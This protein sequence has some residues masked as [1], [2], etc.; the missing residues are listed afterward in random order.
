MFKLSCRRGCNIG[1]D[2]FAD[3]ESPTGVTARTTVS[4]ST[5]EAEYWAASE[6]DIQV[7]YTRNLLQVENMG[8][9]QAPDTQ[10][11]KDS[12]ACTE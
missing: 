11:Y 4:L 1:L 9:P 3:S 8:F 6:M 7:I 5:A 2:G 10:V 12:S